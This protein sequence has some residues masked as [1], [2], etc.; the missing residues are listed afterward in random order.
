MQEN[1]KKTNVILIAVNKFLKI[2][3]P[4]KYIDRYTQKDENQIL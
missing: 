3:H 2:K 4:M 1:L